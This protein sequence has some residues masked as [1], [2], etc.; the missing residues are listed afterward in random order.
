[1]R[2]RYFCT[3]A[4]PPCSLCLSPRKLALASLQLG[5][6]ASACGCGW[7][8]GRL[9]RPRREGRSFFPL[10]PRGE[11]WGEG[12]FLVIHVTPEKGT[13]SG[14]AKGTRERQATSF[15]SSALTAGGTMAMW[16][17]SGCVIAMAIPDEGAKNFAACPGAKRKCRNSTDD[18]LPS[19]VEY[20]KSRSVSPLTI[21]EPQRNSI[22]PSMPPNRDNTCRR[23]SGFS[24]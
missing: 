20:S 24:I 7:E 9:T 4:R 2:N 12:D 1:R 18:A 13:H 23:R 8:R 6:T 5:V 22:M 19:G 11:G 16:A 10:S 21:S 3:E 17:Y 15:A 14:I